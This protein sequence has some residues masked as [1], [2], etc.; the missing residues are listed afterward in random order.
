MSIIEGGA[1]RST[2]PADERAPVDR[3][4]VIAATI[5]ACFVVA[6]VTA[7]SLMDKPTG[8]ILTVVFVVFVHLHIGFWAI[9]LN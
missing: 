9:K 3:K 8:D 4:I 2:E 5:I 6:C 7:L 1:L